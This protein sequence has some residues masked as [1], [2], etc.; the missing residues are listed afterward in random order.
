MVTLRLGD[1]T[2]LTGGGYLSRN[3][4]HTIPGGVTAGGG[5]SDD[6]YRITLDSVAK[7]P[8][9]ASL[10]LLLS[11]LAGVAALRRGAARRAFG[12]MDQA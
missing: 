11:A 8:V 7:I 2:G 1:V 5:A 10:L 6:D 4:M 9:P 3:L 12:G